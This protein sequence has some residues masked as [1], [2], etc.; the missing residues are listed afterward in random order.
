M[1]CIIKPILGNHYSPGASSGSG[2][3]ARNHE[4]DHQHTTS[5]CFPFVNLEFL[6]VFL[7]CRIPNLP[8]DHGTKQV[9]STQLITYDPRNCPGLARSLPFN[10]RQGWILFKRTCIFSG[11]QFIKYLIEFVFAKT[12]KV[13]RIN[14]KRDLDAPNLLHRYSSVVGSKCRDFSI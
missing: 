5:P 7:G 3:G 13:V 11:I 2:Q 12:N 10:S 6:S 1:L 4:M 9:V 8:S 14:F